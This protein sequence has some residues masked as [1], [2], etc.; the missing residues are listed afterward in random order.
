MWLHLFLEDITL[1]FCM[2]WIRKTLR[3][4]SCRSKKNA[5]NFHPALN[6]GEGYLLGVDLKVCFYRV[7]TVAAA[8]LA[9]VSDSRG[10]RPTVSQA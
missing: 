7:Q 3:N 10:L 2:G 9:A 4:G 1:L 5:L 8:D 6:C